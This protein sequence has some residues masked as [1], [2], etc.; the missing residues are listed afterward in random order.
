MGP[1]RLDCAHVLQCA[2][3][4]T[5]HGT[6]SLRGLLPQPPQIQRNIQAEL[7]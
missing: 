1:G 7:R 3:E 4:G 5:T 2:G 6:A